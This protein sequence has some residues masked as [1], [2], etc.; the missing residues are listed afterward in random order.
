MSLTAE[1]QKEAKDKWDQLTRGGGGQVEFFVDTV[2]LDGHWT[3]NQLLII[4]DLL[5]GRGLD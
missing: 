1:Q 5:R 2:Y 3:A 4:A